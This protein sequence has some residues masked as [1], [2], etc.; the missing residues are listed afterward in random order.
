MPSLKEKI[1]QA[2]AEGLSLKVEDSTLI[3]EGPDTPRAE[4]I[5]LDLL[6][7]EDQ[8]IPALASCSVI[9]ESLPIDMVEKCFNG[10]CP[11]LLE[12]KQGQA[13]CR[14]CGVYQRIAS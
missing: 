12:F 1:E 8:I 3:I 14:R 11:A 2:I 5:A 9:P 10:D 7:H 6:Q 4:T 13:Y